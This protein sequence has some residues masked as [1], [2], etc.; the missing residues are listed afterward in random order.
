MV[1]QSL[2]SARRPAAVIVAS[3]QL[4]DM[5][6]D[7]RAGSLAELVGQTVNIYAVE[8]FR[9]ETYDTSGFR[10][11]LRITLEGAETTG[12]LLY[13]GFSKA[14]M[15]IVNTLLG[16]LAV[17]NAILRVFQIPIACHVVQLGN[18]YGLR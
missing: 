5:V 1:T 2:S 14:V 9:S 11:T 8:R 17:D 16:E 3:I 12:D 18:T 15:R 7:D 6:S 10:L 13:T 4:S